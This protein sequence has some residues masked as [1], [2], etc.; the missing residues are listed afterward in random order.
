MELYFIALTLIIFRFGGSLLHMLM[1]L[2]SFLAFDLSLE[3]N[4]DWLPYWGLMSPVLLSA[5]MMLTKPQIAMG[6]WIG[7]S[8]RRLIRA[9]ISTIAILLAS[10]VIWGSWI[11]DMQ[12]ALDSYFVED[13]NLAPITLIPAPLSIFIG[14][15]LALRAFRRR[16]VVLGIFAGLF[17]V[18]YIALYS[19]ILY[20]ALLTIRLPLLAKVIYLSTWLV[21]GGIIGFAVVFR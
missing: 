12:A 21:Y 10:Y 9:L 14:L 2:T 18:P 6:A 16:D 5:P 19:L 1:T 13:V 11:P 20:F 17:F 4:I 3:T 7:Y 15:V 8:P